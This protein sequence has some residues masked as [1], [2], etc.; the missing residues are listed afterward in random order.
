MPALRQ[1]SKKD[2]TRKTAR[3]FLSTHGSSGPDSPL[4]QEDRHE[5]IPADLMDIGKEIMA[6]PQDTREGLVAT[7]QMLVRAQAI[8]LA[9]V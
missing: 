6:M 1:E 3:T 2:D 8:H 9:S 7:I 4:S 5:T